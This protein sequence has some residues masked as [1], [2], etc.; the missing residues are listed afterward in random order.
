MKDINFSALMKA[1]A[2]FDDPHWVREYGNQPKHQLEQLD[3]IDVEELRDLVRGYWSLTHRLLTNLWKGDDGAQV[4]LGDEVSESLRGTAL[5]QHVVDVIA[6]LYEMIFPENR[7]GLAAIR[8]CVDQLERSDFDQLEDALP[9][10]W[11]HDL[12]RELQD[13]IQQYS[14]ITDGKSRRV[15]IRTVVYTKSIAEVG[16]KYQLAR[17]IRE[18]A[19]ADVLS[20]IDLYDG[21]FAPRVEVKAK[22]SDTDY[23][24]CIVVSGSPVN[25]DPRARM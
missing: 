2:Q 21:F 15:V 17:L 10:G 11:Y 9:A 12:A 6:Q 23:S 13:K 25:P 1:V 16:T 5:P 19:F 8:E 14:K 7:S 20:E 18:N 22:K 24:F 4:E 3:A